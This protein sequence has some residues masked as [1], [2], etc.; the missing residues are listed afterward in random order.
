MKEGSSYTDRFS[1][2]DVVSCAVK[3]HE[4][5]W[6]VANGIT[7]TLVVAPVILLFSVVLWIRKKR[8]CEQRSEAGERPDDREQTQPSE[9]HLVYA[10]VHFSEDQAVYSNDGVAQ[11]R[12]HKKVKKEEDAVAYDAVRFHHC[13]GPAL[14]TR[15][16]PTEPQELEERRDVIPHHFLSVDTDSYE[17]SQRY[18]YQ[19]LRPVSLCWVT[20]L[21]TTTKFYHFLACGQR[22]TIQKGK[23]C[24]LTLILLRTEAKATSFYSWD[25][26]RGKYFLIQGQNDWRLTCAP[27]QI[28][29]VVGS[30]VDISCSYRDPDWRTDDDTTAVERLWFTKSTGTEPVDLR[31]DSEHS[32]RVQYLCG[33]N[34]CTLTITDLRESDSAVYK[35]SLTT[36]KAGEKH[37]GEAGVTLSVTEPEDLS[38][39]SEYSGRVQVVETER[40]RSTLRITDLT[41][42]DSAH[43]HF[44]FQRQSFEQET[45]LPGTTLT[46]TALELQVTRTIT[47]HQS[48]TEAELKCLSSCSPADGLSY[49]W[50]RNGEKIMKEGSSYTDRFSPGDVVSCA[51]KGHE[52]HGSP[53]V[54][55]AKSAAAGSITVLLLLAIV[56]LSV[57]LFIRRRRSFKPPC[58]AGQAPEI[59]T[60]TYESP[61]Y[62]NSSGAVQIKPADDILYTSVRFIKNPEALYSNIR[63]TEDESVEYSTVNVKSVDASSRVRCEEGVEDPCALYSTVSKKAEMSL[64]AVLSGLASLLS[65]V[66]GHS[67]WGVS[68][69]PLQLCALKGSTV[70]IGCTFSHPPW[71]NGRDSAGER[72]FWF[73]RLKEKQPEDLRA[74]SKYSGRVQYLCVENGCTLRITDLRES[75]SA[76]YKFRFITNR[77]DGKIIDS[78]GTTLTVTGLQVKVSKSSE[79]SDQRWRPTRPVDLCEDSQYSGRVQVLQSERGRSTL[80]INNLSG[81]DSAEYRFKFT[82]HEFEWQSDLPGTT[83]TVTGSLTSAAAGTITV[84]L[85]VLVLLAV[86]L[87]IRR[88]ELF[89]QQCERRE[90]PDTGAEMNVGPGFDSPSS[91]AGQQDELHYAS[92]SFSQNQGDTVYSNIRGHHQTETE[93]HEEEVEYSVVRFNSSSE[94]GYNINQS[95]TYEQDEFDM[96]QGQR[97]WRVTYTD[98]HICASK[99]STV[100]MSCTY[101]Y[102]EMINRYYT[103]VQGRYWFVK[104]GNYDAVD[105]TTD[106]DYTGRVENHCDERKRCTLRIRDLRE[107]DSAVYKFTFITN[108]VLKFTG[109]PGVTLFVTD[110]DLQVLV[111]RSSDQVELKCHSSFKAPPS[112]VW[113][114]NELKMEEETFSIRVSVNDDNRY[115]C[116][117]K[118]CEDQ[119]SPPVCEPVMIMNSMRLTL[120]LLML[121]TLVVFSLW[122]RKKKT[123]SSNPEPKEAVEMMEVDSGPVDEDVTTAAQTEDREEQEDL[124]ASLLLLVSSQGSASRQLLVS[125]YIVVLQ[126]ISVGDS[127]A[128]QAASSASNMASRRDLPGAS[129]SCVSAFGC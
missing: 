67:D 30:T 111:E 115:S 77:P 122:M 37:T 76:V 129:T 52:S 110:P 106:S 74:D 84:V 65:V 54:C 32:G 125:S 64:I 8:M 96:I 88:E 5:A 127:P 69:T 2:G 79:R 85:L 33:D 90:R 40:G 43:Y 26:V 68:C 35:L 86:F 7:I 57:V 4:R 14:R 98:T 60:Q 118:G 48:H 18:R 38:K 114:K 12:R 51:V 16:A 61:D 71:M 3:G 11:A 93:E 128:V 13:A 24:F 20:A 31:A 92:V 27:T 36:N 73:T 25:D 80:R 102:P 82:T 66:Q 6:K 46:V 15:A 63:T 50:I 56:V 29:A 34:D 1:P 126:P 113:Y 62:E 107:R 9:D 117:L 95:D 81:S 21:S 112:F 108:K 78:P 99:G 116:A 72:R 59:I 97:G 101:S 89:T 45:H 42:T 75:D 19:K 121:I 28:C 123:L 39:D 119:C 22:C 100:E 47:V 53:P 124:S 70:E 10:S 120:M 104:G 103:T 91:A 58:E 87:W 94:S 44:T 109:E 83:L 55:S 41:E 17:L 105:L 23:K 49:V